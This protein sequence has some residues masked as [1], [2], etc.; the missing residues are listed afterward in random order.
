MRTITIVGQK[1]A[2]KTAFVTNFISWL[3]REGYRVGSIKYTPHAHMLDVEGKDSY[4]HRKA[5]ALR[6]AFI[7]PEGAAVFQESADMEKSKSFVETALQDCDILVIEGNLGLSGTKIEVF[8]Y[9]TEGRKPYALTNES[10]QAV[11][12][13]EKLTVSCPIVAA[14]DFQTV[15]NLS[16]PQK[17]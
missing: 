6:A 15:L 11:I 17:K 7:T 5:G 2:G 16:V 1:N 9:H 3:K 8:L 10:I 14:N 13:N 4:R 12:S